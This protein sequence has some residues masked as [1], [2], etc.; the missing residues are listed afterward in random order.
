MIVFWMSAASIIIGLSLIEARR[1]RRLVRRISAGSAQPDEDG[2]AEVG[3][4]TETA[5]A[6]VY[7]TIHFRG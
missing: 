4:T 1:R 7:N 5:A 2:S 6:S 3:Y